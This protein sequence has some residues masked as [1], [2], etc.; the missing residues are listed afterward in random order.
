MKLN[1]AD[2]IV[3]S[4]AIPTEVGIASSYISHFRF[5][6]RWFFA[7]VGG[8]ND[9]SSNHT[10]CATAGIGKALSEYKMDEEKPYGSYRLK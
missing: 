6:L 7:L 10:L 9:I 2:S 4:Q 3:F 1:I 5:V 8:C